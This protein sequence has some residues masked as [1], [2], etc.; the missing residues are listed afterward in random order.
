MVCGRGVGP[1]RFPP[2]LSCRNVQADGKIY[3][4]F[5]AEATLGGKC[6]GTQGSHSPFPADCGPE[7]LS[8]RDAGKGTGERNRA[9]GGTPGFVLG[10]LFLMRRQSH[11]TV[12]G[13]LGVPVR[14]TQP[15]P[16]GG[17]G[18]L[19]STATT[20]SGWITVRN[21]KATT[22]ELLEGA[23]GGCLRDLGADQVISQKQTKH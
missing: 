20:H 23:T 5:I 22:A 16:R 2:G 17:A 11:V 18:A 15:K 4:N 14:T 21:V 6:W 7:A 12:L 9:R 1:V 19:P 13:P 8:E 3:R 10:I